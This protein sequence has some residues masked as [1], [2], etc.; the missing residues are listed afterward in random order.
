MLFPHPF[1]VVEKGSRFCLVF[2]WFLFCFCFVFLLF[3]FCSREC[4]VFFLIVRVVLRKEGKGQG[5]TERKE[6]R[7]GRKEKEDEN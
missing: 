4:L 2:V 6:G 1:S 5:R 7:K 3:F